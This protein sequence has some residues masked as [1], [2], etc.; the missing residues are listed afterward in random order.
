[1][2]TETF[3]K[4]YECDTDLVWN[5]VGGGYAGVEDAA[6][7]SAPGSEPRCTWTITVRA[8]SLDMWSLR[9]SPGDVLYREQRA[10]IRRLSRTGLAPLSLTADRPPTP[11]ASIIG[12]AG[13]SDSDQF[14][15]SFQYASGCSR[16]WCV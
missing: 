13:P 3:C 10:E 1:M 2:S 15:F 7:P 11:A 12:W 16:V 5:E 8:G 6:P 14:S 4:L 9:M